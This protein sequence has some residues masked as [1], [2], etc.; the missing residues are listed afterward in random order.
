VIL[1]IFDLAGHRVATLVDG[2][3]P[4]GWHDIPFAAQRLAS[5]SYLVRLHAGSEVKS[6]KLS[7]VK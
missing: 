3:L 2:E 4:A 5:G 7:L 1:E 6:C